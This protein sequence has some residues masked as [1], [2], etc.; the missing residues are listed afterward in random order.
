MCPVLITYPTWKDLIGRRPTDAEL[1]EELRPLD[2]T[3]TVWL[4]AR[5]N[6]HLALARFHRNLQETA[7]LQ[8][9]LVNLL[10]DEDL[11]AR[12]R[13]KY[14][15]ERLVDRQ[16]FHSLQILTLMKRAM[17]ECMDGGARPDNDRDAA[18]RLGRCLLMTNDLLYTE[19]NARATRA[20]RP[21]THRRRIAL[22]LQLGSGLEINN[23][24]SID[25]SIVRSDIIF[26]DLLRTTPATLNVRQMF[27][28]RTGIAIEDYIDHIF[29]LLAY[30]ITLTSRRIIEDSG[31]ACVTLATVFGESA[32]DVVEQFW[33]MEL[34]DIRVVA[35]S[36]VSPSKLKPHHDF[37]VFRKSSLIE[38]AEGN[39]IPIHLGFLQEKLESGLFWAIF[40][41]TNSS[42]ER[43]QLFT[44]WGHLYE[45]YVS[46]L[47][48]GCFQ[49]CSEAYIP[50]P[51]FLDNDEEAFD[52]IVCRENYWVVMEYKGGFL[53]ATAKYSE[54]ENDF[55][56]DLNR[57]FG[58]DKGA[59]I[60]QLVRKI[61]AVFARKD[62][63]RRPLEGLDSSKVQIV[64]PVLIVQESFVSSEIT[65]P[66][67]IDI[68]GTLKREQELDPRVVCTFPIV[69]DISE[70]ETFKPYLVQNKL[71][72]VD[73]LM[74]RVRKGASGFLSF[75]DFLRDY[76][77]EKHIERVKDTESLQHFRRIMD[78]IS[79][80]F[81][82]K[83]FEPQAS[84]EHMAGPP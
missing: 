78:R 45:A 68:F 5:V 59:G 44:T 11:F 74:A 52:G 1:V 61:G 28:G 22:Q 70:L 84:E 77:E 16:S 47:L 53:N 12:L 46:R 38:I 17:L 63:K 57:K 14:G 60:E 34:S 9:Y 21:S 33:R 58:S 65:V 36:L 2:R 40:N 35:A 54:N 67:L 43:D 72:F 23:P 48:D 25:Q 62:G 30:Y 31:V 42:Q 20:D 4:L 56:G 27:Q 19:E 49:N 69:L 64:I 66:Y 7:E 10:I 39:A 79:E 41:S 26:G 8:T 73:C 13:T 18:Y 83:P 55:L 37:I 15:R 29:G 32:R 76:L 51:R 80:R 24:P 71:S 82:K 50:F 81:F 75:R 6:L 3:H